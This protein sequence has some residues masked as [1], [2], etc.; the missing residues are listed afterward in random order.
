[1]VVSG[2]TPELGGVYLGGSGS[3]NLLDDYEEGTWTPQV[4]G[5]ST[6]GTYTVS[7]SSARYVKIGN[8]V[9]L[10]ASFGFSAASG[11]TGYAQFRNIPFAYDTGLGIAGTVFTANFD[12]STANPATVAISGSFGTSNTVMNLIEVRDAA[13]GI[14]API[15]GISTS[16][17]IGFTVTYTAA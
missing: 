15:S 3:A 5:A 9:T 13:G 1:V 7:I 6:A 12:F 14:D 17:S 2:A 10:W 8:Q 4:Q 16:T 11:G